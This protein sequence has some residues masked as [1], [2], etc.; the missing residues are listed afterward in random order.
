M[1]Y[2]TGSQCRGYG[3]VSGRLGKIK[4]QLYLIEHEQLLHRIPLKG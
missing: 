4:N 3:I 1:K 2:K